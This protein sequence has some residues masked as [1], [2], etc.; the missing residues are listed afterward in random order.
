[1]NYLLFLYLGIGLLMGA[2]ATGIALI[3]CYDRLF[4]NK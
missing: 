2:V 1:M 4:P 3:L